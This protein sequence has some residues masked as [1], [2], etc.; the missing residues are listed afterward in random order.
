MVKR[1]IKQT[2]KVKKE[3]KKITAVTIQYQMIKKCVNEKAFG[4]Q[5]IKGSVM[6]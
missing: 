4:F 6:I 2:P 3:M 1:T 5:P